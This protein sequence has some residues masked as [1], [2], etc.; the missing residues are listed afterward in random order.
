MFGLPLV[1]YKRSRNLRDLLVHTKPVT[2]RSFTQQ[3]AQT[4]THPCNSLRCKTCSIIVDLTTIDINAS[5]KHQVRGYYTCQSSSIIYLISCTLCN[6]VYVGE[7]GC[8]LRERMTG[9]RSAINNKIDTPVAEHF[10]LAGHHLRV[11]VI[12]SASEDVMKRRTVERMWINR[13]RQ[14]THVRLLNRD[15]GLDILLL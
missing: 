13:L 9:H 1:S 4:G 7:T 11:S 3:G 6:A 8:K 5:P 10:Q 12:Q 14:Q 15:D 2:Q